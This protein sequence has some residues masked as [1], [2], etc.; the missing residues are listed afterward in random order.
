VRVDAAE[1]QRFGAI[2][3]GTK[4]PSTT[5]WGTGGTSHLCVQVPVQRTNIQSSGGTAL[6]CD[7]SLGLDW[8]AFVAAHPT[9]QGT[10]FAAGQTLWFQ[11]WL[12]D[13]G[14]PKNSMLSDALAVT[15]MP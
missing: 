7:G 3:Y 1:G 12:R 6:A 5:P 11:G 14:A 2:L 13:I 10:P 8:N 9:A 4:A 15:L